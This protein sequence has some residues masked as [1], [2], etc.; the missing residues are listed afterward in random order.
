MIDFNDCSLNYST[1]FGLKLNGIRITHCIARE[2]DFG[3]ADLTRAVFDGTDLAGSLFMHTN[4]TEADFTK[5]SNYSISAKH[6]QLMKTKFSLPEAMSL[7]YGLDII[8]VDP[9]NE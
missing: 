4:L 8:L 7:L 5:A 3:E 2:V 1:F 9:Q 6:N